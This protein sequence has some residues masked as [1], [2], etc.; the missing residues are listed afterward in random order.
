MVERVCP[1]GRACRSRGD[2]SVDQQGGPSASVGATGGSGAGGKV[3]VSVN[4][5][6]VSSETVTLGAAA[7]GSVDSAAGY[8]FVIESPF[9]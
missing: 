5:N 6:G 7:G 4:E 9:N 2:G 8:T 1:G 3:S